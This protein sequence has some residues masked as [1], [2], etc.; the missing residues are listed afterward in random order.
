MFIRSSRLPVLLAL[1]AA[2]CLVATGCDQFM[3]SAMIYL[4]QSP[5][6]YDKAIAQLKEGL[7]VVP[8]NGNYYRVLAYCYF[9]NRQY[10]ESREAYDNA[11]KFL[12]DKKDSLVKARQ[13]NWEDLYRGATTY[14]NKLAKAPPESVQSFVD[15]AQKTLDNAVIFMPDNDRNMM[16]QAFIYQKTGRAEEARKAYLKIIEINPKNTD[17]LVTLGKTAYNDAKYAEAAE[18][19]KKALAINPADTNTSFM[20]GLSYFAEKKYPEAIDPFRRAATLNPS[21]RDALINLAKCVML[22]D[23]TPQLAIDPLEKAL[24]LKEDDETWYLLGLVA[25][26]RQVND[27]DRGM[28]AFKRATELKP[29]MRDYWVSLRDIYKAKNMK[30]E[31]KQV[32]QKLREMK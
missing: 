30:A 8:E 20:L 22:E 19:F 11:I 29:A 26:N 4:Q 2:L 13:E 28:R 9:N 14:A 25:M 32:E 12:P 17:V 6:A 1:A 21:D 10:K 5:P 23:K 31:L 16:L 3:S 7:T 27:S 18:Y 15:K 24:Q